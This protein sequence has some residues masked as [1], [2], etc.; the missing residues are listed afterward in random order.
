M[1]ISDPPF[2]DLAAQSAGSKASTAR[3]TSESELGLGGDSC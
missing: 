2:C 1:L 3:K